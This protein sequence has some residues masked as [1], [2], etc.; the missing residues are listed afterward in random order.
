MSVAY[1]GPSSDIL[2][3]VGRDDFLEALGDPGLCM[4]I[5]DKV[6]AKME[7]ALRIVLN[8]EVL[9]KLRDV[10]QIKVVVD[11][12][13]HAHKSKNDNVTNLRLRQCKFVLAY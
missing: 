4:R 2:N 8:L 10:A 13:D 3:A 5:L 1:P 7:E 9:D 12:T 11:P 6:P